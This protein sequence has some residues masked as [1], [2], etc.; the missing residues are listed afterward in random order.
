LTTGRCFDKKLLNI[1]FTIAD[2]VELDAELAESLEKIHAYRDMDGDV[3]A[4][5]LTFAT[6]PT[7]RGTKCGA[8]V[9]SNGTT[10]VSSVPSV[11]AVAKVARMISATY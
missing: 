11:R 8:F 10:S 9:P 5:A 4:L 1:S 6:Y 2:V 3:T 7:S